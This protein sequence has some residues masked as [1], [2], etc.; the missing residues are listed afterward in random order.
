MG[1]ADLPALPVPAGAVLVKVC[2]V[3]RCE[4]AAL[5]VGAGANLIGVIFAASK[6]Q[7][8]QKQ[9]EELVQQV[10]S[11]GER[12]ERVPRGARVL[13]E[14]EG[15]EM[16]PF[17]S[18]WMVSSSWLLGDG[19]AISSNFAMGSK[20]LRRACSLPVALKSGAFRS[21]LPAGGGRLHGSEPRGCGLHSGG[22]RFR[23]HPTPWGRLGVVWNKLILGAIIQVFLS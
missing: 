14:S 1:D 12:R 22:L 2:G 16:R 18:R 21:T 11:F 19:G 23:R 17:L 5:A 4:D 10:R 13:K 15:L 7:A 8:T 9:A 3:R 20:A 6:R